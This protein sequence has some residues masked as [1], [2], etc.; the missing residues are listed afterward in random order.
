M[1]SKA[2]VADLNGMKDFKVIIFPNLERS[3][4]AC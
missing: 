3:R 1:F 2:L 4:T